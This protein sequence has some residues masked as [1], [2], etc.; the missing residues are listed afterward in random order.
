MS[1]GTPLPGSEPP[2]EPVRV[3]M[4]DLKPVMTIA[5][6][7]ITVLFFGAQY[8]L[9]MIT[10]SDILF[11]YGGK[12][13]QLIMTGQVWRFLTPALLHGSILHIALNMYALYIIGRRL[14]R[15]YGHWRLLLLYVLS[16]FSGNVFSFVLTPAPSL[17]A[18]TAIF[19]LFAAEG[20][21][22]FQN[23]KLFGSFHTR[24]AIMNLGV[25]LMINLAYGFMSGSN[26]DN[27]G[28]IGGLLGGVFFAW[29]AGPILKLTGQPPFFTVADGRKKEE[30]ILASAVVLV[31]FTIIALIPFLS[32]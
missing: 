25:V 19:G 2:R 10:G 29:K 9:R 27:M 16:A 1:D 22:I 21:F 14:E 11:L 20:M 8:F 18:S 32:L 30:V 24:Q 28:H 7:V 26:V 3:Q 12:I 5:L 13:N 4:P 31:G 6:V 23:R 17:G 15:F